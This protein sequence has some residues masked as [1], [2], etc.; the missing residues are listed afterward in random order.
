MQQYAMCYGTLHIAF[1][2][3]PDNLPLSSVNKQS[4]SQIMSGYLEHLQRVPCIQTWQSGVT[5]YVLVPHQTPILLL[6]AMTTLQ[7]ASNEMTM[8]TL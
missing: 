7:Q 8:M 4:V 2:T 6:C 5:M 3:Y 1:V